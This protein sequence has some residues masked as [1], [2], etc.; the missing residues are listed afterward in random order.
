MT[1]CLEV[2]S[3]SKNN[4]RFLKLTAD[5]LDSLRDFKL[6]VQTNS[7]TA[8]INTD[9]YSALLTAGNHSFTEVTRC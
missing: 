7:D 3:G 6:F 1:Q 9:V 4:Q 2:E 5:R 8:R